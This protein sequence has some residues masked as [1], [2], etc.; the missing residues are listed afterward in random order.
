M[1]LSELKQSFSIAIVGPT[2]SGKSGLALELA[3]QVNGE[4]V[5]CDSLQVYKNF[6]IGTAKPSLAERALVPHHLIDLVSWQETFDAARYRTLALECIAEIHQRQRLPILVGGTGLYFRALCGQQFHDLPHDESLREQLNTLPTDTLYQ[7]LQDLDPQRATEVHP[8]D[9]F[10]LIR[11]CEIN[12]LTGRR[13][14]SLSAEKSTDGFHPTLTVL[15]NPARDILHDKIRARTAAMLKAGLVGEVE[16]LLAA[17]CTE[18]QKP[19]QAIGYRQVCDSLHGRLPEHELLEKIV[20][21]TRQYARKQL[22]WFRKVPVDL[23]LSEPYAVPEA[24]VQIKNQ[25]SI[26]SQKDTDA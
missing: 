13:L 26:A 12:L 22:I 18:K 2:A 6:N 14:A 19:M 3:Q 25:F 20:I 15:C 4:I 21:A 16:T 23:Q 24:I 7:K 9:R 17:G 10:R 8:H 1:K 5:S 11:A